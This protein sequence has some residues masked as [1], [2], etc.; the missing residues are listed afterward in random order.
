MDMPLP[1]PQEQL[2]DLL[3]QAPSH[4]QQLNCMCS[5]REQSTSGAEI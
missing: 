2:W 1:E 5:S 4:Y 3:A